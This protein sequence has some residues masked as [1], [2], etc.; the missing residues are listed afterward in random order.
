MIYEI[1]KKNGR[2]KKPTARGA[3][4]IG[5]I[6]YNIIVYNRVAFVRNAFRVRLDARNR[7]RNNTFYYRPRAPRDHVRRFQLID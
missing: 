5:L 4:D 3:Y 1:E 6:N 7:K 2:G